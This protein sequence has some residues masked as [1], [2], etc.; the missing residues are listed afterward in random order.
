MPIS[1]SHDCHCIESTAFFSVSGVIDPFNKLSYNTKVGPD[2]I[3]K[4]NYRSCY[5]L[6][7]LSNIYIIY[8]LKMFRNFRKVVSLSRSYKLW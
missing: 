7:I 1:S 6:A 3:L 2:L 4:I 8:L 5:T